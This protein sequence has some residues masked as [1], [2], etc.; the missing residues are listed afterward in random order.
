MTNGVPGELE[1]HLLG[2]FR[3]TC[4]PE[5]GLCC[6]AEPRADA[7]DRARLV[8]VDP[9][10]RFVGHG[11]DQFLASRPNGGACQF[12]SG[13]RC[14]AHA[15]RPHPCREF[16]VS[17]HVG[18]RLQATLVLSCPGVDLS[19]LVGWAPRGEPVSVDFDSELASVRARLGPA[20]RVRLETAERRGRKLERALRA[21]GRWEDDEVVRAAWRDRIPRPG[22][23][24]FPVEDPPKVA[25]GWEQ[26]PIFYDG[27]D[28]PV[29]LAQAFGAWQLLEVSP[30]GGGDPLATIPSPNHP[31]EIDTAADQVLVGYLRY[32]LYRDAF[33]AA[34]QLDALEGTE[35]SMTEWVGLELRTL[36]ATVLARASVRAKL[37]G[38][39]TAPLTERE[40]V[41]GIRATDMDWL[42]RPTWGDRF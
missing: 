6:Y 5:C 30:E 4:R 1:L 14:R 17:V 13:N 2:G 22:V 25:D 37:R 35:G 33:L 3:Y 29:A 21:E 10:V 11:P 9:E 24:D 16:P 18:H 38:G 32:C 36:G 23:K 20:H 28:R 40:V 15:V 19:S 41:D 12:L 26:L 34:A 7:P 27:R 31:P 42:D 39:G 8:A